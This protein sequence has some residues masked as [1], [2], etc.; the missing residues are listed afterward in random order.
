MERSSGPRVTR[1]TVLAGA[2]GLGLAGVARAAAPA[3]S[4]ASFPRR[5]SRPRPDLRAP[6]SEV[7]YSH[8]YMESQIF[9]PDSKRFVLHRSGLPHGADKKDPRHQFV[10]CDIEDG[11]RITPLTDELGTCGPAVSPDGKYLYYFVD[12]TDRKKPVKFL[13]LRRVNLDGS[14]RETI[15]RIEGRIP[16]TDYHLSRLYPLSTI[17]SDG[18][19]VATSGF[20]GDGS[21][22]RAPYGL[23]VFDVKT[24]AAHV[25]IAGP[26]LGNMH[27]QYSR[28]LDPEA[29]HDVLIQENHGKMADERG[30]M[31]LV[32]GDKNGADIHVIRDDGTNLRDMPWGRDGEEY[33]Q[34]HQCWRGRSGWAITSTAPRNYDAHLIESL[35]VP[36]VGHDGLKAPGGIRNRLSR[37]HDVPRFHHF[38]TDI[39]GRLFISDYN[40]HG[41]QGMI[42]M[43]TFGEPGRDAIRDWRFIAAPKSS[44]VKNA[45]LHPFLSPNGRLA[46]FNSDESGVLQTYMVR[47]A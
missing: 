3:T 28:S 1:R 36:H 39:E 8:I 19:R 44:C 37:S 9:T 14:G 11:L 7:P 45:H 15:A 10:L 12:H 29:R 27:P 24:G 26:N 2:V 38:A 40:P 46:F 6:G 18:S 22:E 47:L 42:I 4:Q 33:C 32:D 5:Q 41:P 17:S 20:L 31:V 13:E 25:A 43:G 34:G 23:V 30:R 35:P 16:G 21:S